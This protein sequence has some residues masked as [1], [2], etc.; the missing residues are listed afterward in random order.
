[1][2][3]TFNSPMQS[4]TWEEDVK[5]QTPVDGTWYEITNYSGVGRL[6]QVGA[7]AAVTA[8]AELRITTD[9]N[10]HIL[11]KTTWITAT[12]AVG[13]VEQ[14]FRGGAAAYTGFNFNLEFTT[15]LVI[16]IRR[17]GDTND[18]VGWASYGILSK[19]FKREIIPAGQPIPDRNG[20]PRPKTYPFDL[21]L[22]WFQ[23]SHGISN[24]IQFPCAADIDFGQGKLLVPSFDLT[25]GNGRYKYAQSAE[26][27]TIQ[28]I[29]DGKE[30]AID[31]VK[32]VVAASTVPFLITNEDF[33]DRF[34]ESEQ[35][36]LVDSA[37]K[38]VKRFLYELRMTP[39]INLKNA[40]LIGAITLAESAGILTP[41][42]AAQ[43]LMI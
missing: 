43:I 17:D 18:L 29:I 3:G 30:Y 37:N 36:D 11:P 39:K 27:K 21:M 34:L 19:E 16:E 6:M 28:R 26:S 5:V 10:A 2:P 32:G 38:K 9:G 35:D 7:Y 24:K 1:M 8:T 23:G 41:G 42:R 25:V 40:K 20:T 31:I 14:M 13:A 15:T 22:I 4:M 12:G 33:W